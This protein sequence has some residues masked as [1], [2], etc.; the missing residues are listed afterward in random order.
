MIPETG[1]IVFWKLGGLVLK[2]GMQQG[3]S[4]ALIWAW[5]CQTLCVCSLAG[6]NTCSVQVSEGPTHQPWGVG[7]AAATPSSMAARVPP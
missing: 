5:L 7:V 3:L 4:L 1:L 2:S 6:P